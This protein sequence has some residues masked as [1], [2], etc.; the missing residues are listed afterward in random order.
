MSKQPKQ[1]QPKLRRLFTTGTLKQMAVARYQGGITWAQP[2]FIGLEQ[3]IRN[4]ILLFDNQ[5]AAATY[6][7]DRG[8]YPFV[9]CEF[10]VEAIDKDYLVRCSEQGPHK[11]K[12]DYRQ[13]CYSEP[14]IFDRC[15]WH[16][17]KEVE[18]DA[19]EESPVK[20]IDTTTGNI[21][22]PVGQ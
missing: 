16:T 5:E 15:W 11:F 3:G 22:I 21:I 1:T 10:A 8:G 4:G 18:E 20:S 17:Y 19:V 6:Q 2:I 7:R 9:V 13:W 12:G 14:I